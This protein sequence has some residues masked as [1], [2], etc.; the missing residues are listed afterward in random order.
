MD[1]DTEKTMDA[2]IEEEEKKKHAKAYDDLPC[3]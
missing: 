2:A 3:M 1:K